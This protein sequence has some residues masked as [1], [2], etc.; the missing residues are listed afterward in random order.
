FQPAIAKASQ[1]MVRIDAGGL[2]GGGAVIS[3]D[4]FIATTGFVAVAPGKQ[5][6]VTF[7]DGRQAKAITLGINRDADV[8]MLKI[9]TGGKWPFVEVGDSAQATVDGRLVALAWLGD[10]ADKP[11][12]GV[13][14][15]RYRAVER[16]GTW[17]SMMFQRS[18]SGGLLVNRAG[19][20][21]GL[22][23]RPF[24]PG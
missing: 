2:R 4:G 6:D 1:A 22:H 18:F 9:T 10:L 12:P 13:A 19:Q 11:R 14:V 8:S 20:L 15:V 16:G 17:I 21:V 7:A 23:S 5:V 24:G 3:A